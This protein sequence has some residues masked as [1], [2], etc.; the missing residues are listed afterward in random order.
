M[1]V[2]YQRGYVHPQIH[3]HVVSHDDPRILRHLSGNRV[4]LHSPQ[5]LSQVLMRTPDLAQ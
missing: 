5:L 2:S 1:V 3:L 4:Q